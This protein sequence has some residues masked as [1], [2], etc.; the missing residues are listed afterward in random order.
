MN[1]SGHRSSIA[2]EPF[3]GVG[4]GFLSRR[5]RAG[6]L[7]IYG[8]FMMLAFGAVALGAGAAFII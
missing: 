4:R 7:S 3:D 1:M 6:F 2:P 8:W 5:R